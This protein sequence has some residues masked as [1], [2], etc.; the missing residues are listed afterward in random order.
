MSVFS[1]L[2]AVANKFYGENKLCEGRKILK[3]TFWQS[4]F[5]FKTSSHLLFV[6]EI[7][8]CYKYKMLK[9]I[10]SIMIMQTIN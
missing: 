4:L 1:F 5:L 9:F 10:I 2:M 8:I 3:K 6:Y 7:I